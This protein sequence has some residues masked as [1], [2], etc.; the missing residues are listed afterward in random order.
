MLLKTILYAC[1]VLFVSANALVEE[2]E[3]EEYYVD[4]EKGL[5]SPQGCGCGIKPV[6]RSAG[7]RLQAIPPQP[8]SSSSSSSSCGCV[9][10]PPYPMPP[11]H[12]CCRVCPKSSSSSTSSCEHHF[13]SVCPKKK[14]LETVVALDKAFIDLI[15]QGQ[16]EEAKMML[17]PG[18]TYDNLDE[19]AEGPVCEVSTGLIASLLTPAILKQPQQC[20]PVNFFPFVNPDALVNFQNTWLIDYLRC[21]KYNNKDN[22]V[23]TTNVEIS[24][25]DRDIL[26]AARESART[27]VPTYGCNFKLAHWSMVNLV[28][29]PQVHLDTLNQ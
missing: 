28:C 16:L 10:K 2:E 1:C 27:W 29:K 12:P 3:V 21:A 14:A 24:Y 23:T 19:V 9:A 11:R 7:Q 26:T 6:I 5:L 15:N 8:R 4:V 22:S 17:S 18:A 13:P 20:P 25:V